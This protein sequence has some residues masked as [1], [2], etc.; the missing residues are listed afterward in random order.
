[1]GNDSYQVQIP[2]SVESPNSKIQ[3]SNE[4]QRPNEDFFEIGAGA[5]YGRMFILFI[6]IEAKNLSVAVMS[7]W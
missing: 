5:G 3:L 2:I 1:M 4:C 7:E 6:L